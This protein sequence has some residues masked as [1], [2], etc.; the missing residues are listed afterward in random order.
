MIVTPNLLGHQPSI[1]TTS[2]GIREDKERN[3]EIASDRPKL[4]VLKAALEE[5][6]SD[7]SSY[8]ARNRNAFDWWHSRW[9]GQ[10]KDGLKWHSA[11]GPESIWP[12]EG[13]SDTRTHIISKIGGQHETVGSFALRNMKI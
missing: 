4:E 2:R 9:E 8:L 1:R 11:G 5:S 12:W 13:A 6:Q 3:L 10:T 7:A